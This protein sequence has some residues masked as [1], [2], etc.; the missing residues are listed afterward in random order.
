LKDE[1]DHGHHGHDHSTIDR[2][3]L[4]HRRA[5]RAIWVS[6]AALGATALLQF[7]IVAISDSVALFADALHNIGDVL[8]TGSLIVA[9]RLSRRA[10]SD[11][12]PYGWA[13]AEDLAGLLIVVAIALSAVLAGWDSISALLSGGHEVRNLPAAFSAAVLGVVGNEGVAIYKIRVGRDIGSVALVADGQHARTD[14]LASAA[15]AVGIAGVW[16]GFPLADPLAGLAITLAIVWILVDVGR[17]VL[18]RTMDAVEPGLVPRIREVAT[19]VDG[20]RDVHDVRARYLG[21]SLAVQLHADADPDLPLRH[22][23][24]LAERVRHELVHEMPEIA[25]VDV[26]LDPAGEHDAHAETAHHFHRSHRHE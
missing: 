3:L 17:D 15:A 1:H 8:G 2:E 22:A 24:A 16:L 12:F 5:M 21:R 25:A 6:V 14:G 19:G 7:A 13:R 9:L 23:H 26:H 20:V 11:Q 4:T 10:A 18:R